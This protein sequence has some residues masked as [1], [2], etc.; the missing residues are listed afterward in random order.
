[1]KQL[2]FQVH[3]YPSWILYGY[4]CALIITI[5]FSFIHRQWQIYQS[6]NISGCGTYVIEQSLDIH[7][8]SI[9]FK[10]GEYV[11]YSVL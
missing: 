11:I 2:G 1:M 6:R 10:D 5:P 9:V 7:L 8:V 3:V 4:Y